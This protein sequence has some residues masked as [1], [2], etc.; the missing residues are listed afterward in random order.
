[1]GTPMYMSPEQVVETKSVTA[2][3]D[4]Y[5]L[6]VV[7]WQMVTGKRP[8]DTKTLSDFQLKSKIVHEPLPLTNTQWDIH[9]QKATAKKI[10][11]RFADCQ[12]WLNELSNKNHRQTSDPDA[13]V[14]TDVTE[15]KTIITS[16]TVQDFPNVQIGNQVWMEQNLNV[17]CFRNG[18]QIPHIQSIQEWESYGKLG[19]PAW[20]YYENKEEYEYGETYGKLYNWFAVKDERGLAPLGWHIPTEEEWNLLIDQTGG[21]S[22]SGNHLK[23][24]FGWRSLLFS[25]GNGTNASNFSALPGGFRLKNGLFDD[26][27]STGLW[28][29]TTENK[30]SKSLY[31][32]LS[33]GSPQS[34]LT[35]INQGCG[36]SVRCLKN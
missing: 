3:S 28:W 15:P 2:A 33:M 32:Q 4:I 29:S 11:D 20:C 9:I 25:S 14:F 1:M 35:Y 5:S 12:N 34:N 36:L 27:E 13:T 30:E 18:D 31:L 17:K 16:V 23:H 26:L 10:E 24:I 6:G 22:N 8:Y 19:K 7:L 21:K